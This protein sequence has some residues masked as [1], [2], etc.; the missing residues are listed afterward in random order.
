MKIA[1]AEFIK[2][3]A[4]PSDWPEPSYPEIAFCGRSNVGKSTL[5]NHLLNRKGMARVSRT[6]GR[7]RLLNF[8]MVQ[9]KS[10]NLSPQNLPDCNFILVDLP[11]FG[12]ANV[13][14]EERSSWRPGIEAYF[15]QRSSLS[16]V[17]LL[18]DSRRVLVMKEKPE[19]LREEEELFTYLTSLHKKVLPVITKS[20]QLSK[21]EKKP[22][23]E[24]LRRRIGTKPIL[25]SSLSSEG[26]SDLHHQMERILILSQN[27]DH[28]TLPD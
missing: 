27:Q 13:S 9:A 18:F 2:S 11:G 14:K 12:Y 24:N 28:A 17:I 15:T 3:A 4:K 7:T 25:F 6:P 26:V 16:A 23:V 21:H 20:D 5:L 10:E 8:F 22:L 1:H 19:I